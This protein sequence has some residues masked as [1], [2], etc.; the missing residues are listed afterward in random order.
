MSAKRQSIAPTYDHRETGDRFTVETRINNQH[1][2]VTPTR[3][4]FIFHRVTVGWPDLLRSLLRRKLTIEVIVG[5]DREIVDDV[6]ELDADA[7]TFNSTRRDEWNSQS[8]TA[9]HRVSEEAWP[10]GEKKPQ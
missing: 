2:G 9:L 1:L 10:S 8:N 3:D 5:G 7:L 6:L 4:P